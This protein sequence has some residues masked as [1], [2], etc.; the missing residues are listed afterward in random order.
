MTLCMARAAGLYTQAQDGTAA[1]RRLALQHGILC[2]KL[3][4]SAGRRR[5]ASV[6]A[7]SAL[8]SSA[9]PTHTIR[10][11]SNSEGVNVGML[12]RVAR[13][14][15]PED[16]GDCIAVL[17]CGWKMSNDIA[18]YWVLAVIAIGRAD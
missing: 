9:R 13:A 6:I 8:V 1:R 15:Q 10:Q 18:W 12:P 14:Y 7:R 2:I 3:A 4:L 16:N 5:N 11:I 17:P